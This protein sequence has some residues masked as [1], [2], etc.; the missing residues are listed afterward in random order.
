MGNCRGSARVVS[1]YGI[2]TPA[3]SQAY[4]DGYTPMEYFDKV[5]VRRNSR[6]LS[7]LNSACKPVSQSR[8]RPTVSV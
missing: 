4:K 8:V 7:A 5:V 6:L 1:Q 3:D 2:P